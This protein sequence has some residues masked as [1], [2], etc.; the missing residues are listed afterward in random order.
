M[1]PAGVLLDLLVIVLMLMLVL[2]TVS[3]A[4]GVNRSYLCGNIR[5]ERNSTRERSYELFS[6]FRLVVGQAPGLPVG[7]HGNRS[8]CPTNSAIAAALRQVRRS[9]SENAP[10]QDQFSERKCAGWPGVE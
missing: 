10:L 7:K 1:H 9:V 2:V 3:W 5:H 4:I 8:G 6:H